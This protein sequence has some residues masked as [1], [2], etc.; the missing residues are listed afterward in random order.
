[1]QELDNRFFKLHAAVVATDRN[2]GSH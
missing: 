2:D 1:M